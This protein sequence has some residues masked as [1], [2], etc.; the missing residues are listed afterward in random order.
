MSQLDSHIR[1]IDQARAA[2]IVLALLDDDPDMLNRALGEANAD[3]A[4]HLLIGAL[5]R[6]LGETLMQA[7]GEANTRAVLQ[8]VILDAQTFGEGAVSDE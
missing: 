6:A 3:S 5:A 8:R 2:R 4:V 7:T 1:P